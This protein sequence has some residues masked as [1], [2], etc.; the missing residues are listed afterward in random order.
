MTI[1][2]TTTEVD[3]LRARLAANPREHALA[4][5]DQ[6]SH[7]SLDL[8]MRGDYDAA[9][10]CDLEAVRVLAAHIDPLTL[11]PAEEFKYASIVAGIASGLLIDDRA[12]LAFGLLDHA[13]DVHGRLDHL[14]GQAIEQPTFGPPPPPP[15]PEEEAHHEA[16]Q[17]AMDEAPP[18]VSPYA[19][20]HPPVPFETPAGAFSRPDR[21]WLQ[22]ADWTFIQWLL[23]CARDRALATLGE[24][25]R[26][27]ADAVE[28]LS[29]NLLGTELDY[30]RLVS[31]A[32]AALKTASYLIA[33]EEPPEGPLGW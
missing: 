32:C 21:G 4:L 7:L 5:A 24:K 20:D 33:D 9:A 22:P 27:L 19:D 25:D 26:A 16:F 8:A 12:E 10:A 17:R 29:I 30:A 28:A 11:P 2:Q 3:R 1:E 18:R 13:I 14:A 31:C 15:S 23:L 6:L